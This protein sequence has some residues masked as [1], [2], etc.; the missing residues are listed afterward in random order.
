MIN[1]AAL[2]ALKGT[3]NT[4]KIITTKQG[5]PFNETKKNKAAL[6]ELGID[7]DKM[8]KVT[9][10][11]CFAGSDIDYKALYEERAGEKKESRLI[12]T[13]NTW[14][15]GLE[16]ILM[17]NATTG[18]KLLR[19]YTDNDHKAKSIYIYEGQIFD[20]YKEKYAEY[21]KKPRNINEKAEG[22][23]PMS[24]TIETITSIEVDGNKIQ[25]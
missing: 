25:L 19:I 20:D 23:C 2:S 18:N 11:N 16:G 7:V 5:S 6:L 21:L 13:N 10:F 9:T 12:N 22:L 4:V 14:V 24:L 3:H 15:E 8:V 1:T 17:T